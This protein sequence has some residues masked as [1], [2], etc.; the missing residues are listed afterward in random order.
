[1]LRFLSSNKRIAIYS[2]TY[3]VVL[4]FVCYSSR[5]TLRRL[6]EAKPSTEKSAEQ[7]NE[8]FIQKYKAR[9]QI[10]TARNLQQGARLKR[11]VNKLIL[12]V[13]TGTFHE[14]S[15][16]Y[17]L[18]R[19]C[20]F[21]RKEKRNNLFFLNRMR[22][23]EKL[24]CEAKSVHLSSFKQLL[25]SMNK[26]AYELQYPYEAKCQ[27]VR[28]DMRAQLMAQIRN[29]Q[30]PVTCNASHWSS[31]SPKIISDKNL[32]GEKLVLRITKALM[33]SFFSDTIFDFEGPK[34]KDWRQ[35]FLPISTCTTNNLV[36]FEVNL[37][38][39]YFNFSPDKFRI[40]IFETEKLVSNSVIFKTHL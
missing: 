11:H 2:S 16:E 34:T 23:L 28:T 40:S 4:T 14:A 20:D 6:F 22:T 17:F 3:L 13:L 26:L 10:E 27:E 35:V 39:S 18:R 12:D 1:M 32:I 8:D 36:S 9:T 37:A 38:E 19:T 21:V 7:L 24:S 15:A 25:K 29:I 31:I 33:H 30:N 5:N